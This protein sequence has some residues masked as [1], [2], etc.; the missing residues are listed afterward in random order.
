MTKGCLKSALNRF[1][2]CWVM[3]ICSVLIAQTSE[4]QVRSAPTPAVSQEPAAALPPPSSVARRLYDQQRDKLVQVR[5]LVADSE[6]QASS[7]S[8]FAVTPEG[9]LVSNYH[10]I[11]QLVNEPDRYRAE[12]VRTDG[13]K[14]KLSIVAIDVQHDL[15][16]LQATRDASQGSWPTVVLAPDGSLKQGDKVFSLGNPLDL[17]FA[18]SEGTYNGLP[19]RSLYPHLL[20]TGAMNPGVSGGP[21]MDE[22][23]RVVG[24]NVAGYG[25]SAELTNFQ[26]PVNFVRELLT[27]ALAVK[28]TAMPVS[29]ASLRAQRQAQLIAHQ[30]LMLDGLS[31]DA[32]PW[33]TQTLGP[34]R[35]PVIPQTLA[36][37]WGDVSPS[38]E[39]NVRFESARCELQSALYIGSSPR[40][41]SAS[42]QHEVMT[43]QRLGALRLAYLRGKSM[44]N[45]RHNVRGQ[46]KHMTASRC[47]EGFV[48][49]DALDLRVVTCLSAYRKHE[50]LY[51]LFT[52]VTTM[53]EDGGLESTLKLK[54]VTSEAGLAVSKRFVQSIGRDARDARETTKPSKVAP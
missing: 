46:S 24:V 13:V 20:F 12:Y 26:V 1:L 37:C 47:T 52:L 3:A 49:Q 9:L 43:N 2:P 36:R 41:G 25:R 28:P 42:T 44:G 21:A 18:I 39:K 32:L 15:A 5:I 33:R 10:V 7:G 30:Q 17:G 34:Y 6:S 4:A 14:G 8:A 27:K 54:G 40:M 38:D 50:A 45:E 35:I 53:T 23:G 19:E 16:V 31:T 29:N 22:S 11:A 48:R 51:D